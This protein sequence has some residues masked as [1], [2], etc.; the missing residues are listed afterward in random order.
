MSRNISSVVSKKPDIA[1]ILKNRQDGKRN[2]SFA[3]KISSIAGSLLSAKGAA[4]ALVLAVGYYHL[5]VQRKSVGNSV[6]NL[7]VCLPP[8]KQPVGLLH[9]PVVKKILAEIDQGEIQLYTRNGNTC[10]ARSLEFDISIS[11]DAI[12]Q[13][14]DRR[15]CAVASTLMAVA[16]KDPGFIPSIISTKSTSPLIWSVKLH[17]ADSTL[18][19]RNPITIDVSAKELESGVYANLYVDHS[20]E[21]PTVLS[22]AIDKALKSRSDGKFSGIDNS[23][24]SHIMPTLYGERAQS[25]IAKILP[26][27]K[28]LPPAKLATKLINQWYKLSESVPGNIGNN[29]ILVKPCTFGFIAEPLVAFRDQP[30]FYPRHAFVLEGF[31]MTDKN[32]PQMLLR[33]P[34]K[35]RAPLN[36]GNNEERIVR[37]GAPQL[38]KY[39]SNPDSFKFE[40]DIV[41]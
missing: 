7:S 13:R 21:W 25:A 28:N 22:A 16:E 37:V 32:N 27:D 15:N 39:L 18:K 17:Q 19:F 29:D 9:P 14:P 12:E 26:G 5:S 35:L 8:P 1:K 31:D 36:T 33:Q 11:K 41:I 34:L 40:I 3:G 6:S 20:Y 23:V 24:S 10:K 2:A 4:G 38:E 30:D